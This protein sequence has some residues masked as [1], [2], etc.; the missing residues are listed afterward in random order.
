MNEIFNW[1][2]EIIE[3]V[4]ADESLK[5]Q[6]ILLLTLKILITDEIYSPYLPIFIDNCKGEC[7]EKIDT[8]E[9]D[10]FINAIFENLNNNFFSVSDSVLIKNAIN[11]IFIQ[12]P[13]LSIEQFIFSEETFPIFKRSYW[14]LII[15]ELVKIVSV[16]DKTD[17]TAPELL[18]KKLFLDFY[19][20]TREK[21]LESILDMNKTQWVL[22]D[23]SIKLIETLKTM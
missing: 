10:R 3:F 12:Q 7:N 15:S 22:K 2:N 20:K 4:L 8:N 11:S 18:Y 23:S 9:V 21:F 14:R 6:V 17:K 13:D 16:L 5:K 1:P 19:E